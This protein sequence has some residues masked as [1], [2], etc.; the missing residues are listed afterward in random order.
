MALWGAGNRVS[1]IDNEVLPR[2][3]SIED[4]LTKQSEALVQELKRA[5]RLPASQ[6]KNRGQWI[7]SLISSGVLPGWSSRLEISSWPREPHISMRRL[8]S[9]QVRSGEKDRIACTEEELN[10]RFGVPEP[11]KPNTREKSLLEIAGLRPG[12]IPVGRDLIA[13]TTRS[14]RILLP[15][16]STANKVILTHHSA[17][18]NEEETEFTE[19]AAEVLD[20]V[21][22]ARLLM[23]RCR[24]YW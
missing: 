5:G 9:S 21:E 4:V 13:Q 12:L 17:D 7:V 8:T 22:K 3:K 6:T 15:D 18:G 10:L 14:E 11:P 23:M 16:G 1:R 24:V 19:D 2:L 20:K